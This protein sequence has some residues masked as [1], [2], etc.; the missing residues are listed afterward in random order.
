MSRRKSI[1]DIGRGPVE[2]V[3]QH[4]RVVALEGE[5]RLDLGPD[6]LHPGGHRLLGVERA[7]RARPGV[8]DQPGRPADQRQRPVAGLLQPARGQHLDEV[9]VVQARGG[10]VEA[11]VEGD[12]SRVQGLAQRTQV[13]AH[14]RSG[15][16]TG[17]RRGVR[18]LSSRPQPAGCTGPAATRYRR[19]VR[20]HA[21]LVGEPEP[22]RAGRAVARDAHPRP[23][24]R[25]RARPGRPAGAR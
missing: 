9:P 22:P 23:G 7:L 21:G 16:A 11:D 20:R 10:R 17:S 19:P 4:G 13:G 18:P 25:S 3:D 15:R 1:A 6:V 12:R 5:V 8:A 24:A 2:V 14:A